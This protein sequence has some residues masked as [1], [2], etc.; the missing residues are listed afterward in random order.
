MAS[1]PGR[2]SQM[3]YLIVEF[4]D[5]DFG[6][7]IIAA[8]ER[9]WQYVSKN[10]HVSSRIPEFFE[11][12]HAVNALEPMIMRLFVLEHACY[13]VEFLTRCLVWDFDKKELPETRLEYYLECPVKFSESLPEPDN[14]ETA[15]LDLTTGEVQVI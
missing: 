13:D 8:L 11:K 9:L 2:G 7:P 10:A 14:G 6:I 5:N 3:K 15:W 1:G 12:L 4:G